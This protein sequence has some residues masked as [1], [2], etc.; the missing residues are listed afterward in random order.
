MFTKTNQ[1][2]HHTKDIQ[3][4]QYKNCEV[5]MEKYLHIKCKENC[6][7]SINGTKAY[8][9]S[10]QKPLDLYLKKECYLNF[11][12]THDEFLPYTFHTA[13]IVQNQNILTV[14]H[15]MHTEIY[16]NPTH[17][18]SSAPKTVFVEKKIGALNVKIEADDISYINIT[19]PEHS[20]TRTTEKF[21]T[22]KCE[23]DNNIFIYGTLQNSNIYVL[24]FDPNKNEIVF[25]NIGELI[26]KDKNSIKFLTNTKN[27]ANHG[28]V[29]EYDKKSSVVDKYAVYIDQNPQRTNIIDIIPYAFLES[30]KIK[31][32]NLARSYLVD[33]FV[34]NQNL[35]SYFGEID[36]IFLNPYSTELEYTILSNGVSKTFTFSVENDKIKDI[37]QIK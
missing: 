26:E 32:F 11:L 12:P 19:S 1:L 21:C 35:E 5:V 16:F 34:T 13:N 2:I 9:I 36:D 17:K 31:D 30:V 37:E 6:I 33:T 3:S 7:V 15:P 4:I 24:I 18:K 10:N 14:V 8:H 23:F 20:I 29:Y 28:I 25:E 22:C 27:L